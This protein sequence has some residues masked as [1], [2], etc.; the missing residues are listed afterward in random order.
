MRNPAPRRPEGEAIVKRRWILILELH[1][2]SRAA[3]DRLVN[4][5]IGGVVANGR[6][7]SHLLAHT[8]HI[9]KLQRLRPRHYSGRP[10]L[11]AVRGLHKRPTTPRCPHHALIHWAHSNQTLRSP[12]ILRRQFWL[13]NFVGK[14]RQGN[15][16]N[17]QNNQRTLEHGP[18]SRVRIRYTRP[19]YRAAVKI[20]SNP[21]SLEQGD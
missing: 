15:G 8:L 5:K 18:I 4:A 7:V 9:A 6:E 11:A 19:K 21:Q 12:A 13:M 10:R 14:T 3:V 17:R 20:V 1:G 16:K 2:P